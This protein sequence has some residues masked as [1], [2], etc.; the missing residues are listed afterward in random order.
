MGIDQ[1][2]T[3]Q[4][5]AVIEAIVADGQAEFRPGHI[6][7]ALRAAGSPMLSWEIRGEL[8]RLEAEGLITADDATGAF[9][10]AKAASKKTG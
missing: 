6:A 3:D 9:A 10:L 4:V 8:S 7:E 1:L 5:Y 2:R